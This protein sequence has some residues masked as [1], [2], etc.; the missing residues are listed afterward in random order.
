VGRLKIGAQAAALLAVAGLLGLLVWDVA[1]RGDGGAATALARGESPPAP[2]LELPR[3]DGNGTLSLEDFRGKGVV[4]NFWASW[5]VPCKDEAPF[6]Q[7]T[8]V[9]N[10]DRGLV[11]LGVDVDDLTADARRFVKRYGLTYPNVR[12]GKKQTVGPWGLQ[13]FPE[14]FFVDRNGRLVGDRIVGGVDIERNREAFEQ[15]ITLALADS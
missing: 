5:C 7:K 13:A 10:R 4:V 12:D 6:L 2:K 1:Q 9:E 8:W 3:L 11:V 15:G 14:T